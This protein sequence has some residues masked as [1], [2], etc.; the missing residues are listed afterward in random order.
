MRNVIKFRSSE[1]LKCEKDICTYIYT[2]E[3]YLDSGCA[4]QI[5][6]A[7]GIIEQMYWDTLDKIEKLPLERNRTSLALDLAEIRC[8]YRRLARNR[9]SE[10]AKLKNMRK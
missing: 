2:F 5:I 4:Q 3:H 9:I 8:E 7:E 10:L 1:Y 6:A